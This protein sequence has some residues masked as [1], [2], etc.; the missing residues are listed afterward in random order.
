[1]LE[2]SE[3]RV[4]L[5]RAGI[6]GKIIEELYISGNRIKILKHHVLFEIDHK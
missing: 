4:E 1:M 5:L 3:E 2:T 6:Y